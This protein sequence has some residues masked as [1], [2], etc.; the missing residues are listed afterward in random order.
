MDR[1]VFPPWVNQFS[2]MAIAGA[3]GGAAYAGGLLFYATWPT[4][5]HSGYQ[6]KQPIPFSHRLHA[7]ELKMDCRYCHNTVDQAAHAAVPASNVCGNCHK[8]LT[9]EGTATKVAVHAKSVK[10]LPL[11]ESLATGQPVEWNRVHDL[12][13][14][15]YFNHSVHVNRGVSCVSCHGRIDKMDVVYQHESLSM[16]WCLDCHRNPAPHI[17]PQEYITKLDWDPEVTEGITKEE[18]GA[19]LVELNKINPSTSCSTCHR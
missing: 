15:V 12:A 1:F 10:L 19:Q 17:R 3:L 7:G 13:D 11:R 9:P 6:P 8:G 18:I 16:S 4:V 5:M 2:I 14:Y